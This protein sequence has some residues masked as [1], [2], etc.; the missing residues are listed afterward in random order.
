MTRV[1]RKYVLDTNL[2]IDA[3]RDP[4]A[5]EALQ[6]FHYLFAP[7]EYLSAVVAQE[8]LAGVRS[9][10]DQQAL[11]RH[12]LRPFTR[13]DRLVSP[14]VRVW[15]ESG[16]VLADLARSEGLELARV[17]KA[18]GNDILLALSCRENGMILVTDNR[19]DFER[20]ARVATCQFVDPWP[21]PAG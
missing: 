4:M 15:R 20:I 6:R 19:R 10:A 9:P 1:E 5:N 11:E 7:F 3:Y 18:F 17:S 13:R 2:F 14:S 16:T 12:V 8:L 21:H